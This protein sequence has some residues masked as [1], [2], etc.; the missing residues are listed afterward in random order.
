[1]FDLALSSHGDLIFSANRD[2]AGISGT[3]LL[4]QRMRIR[5][6]LQKGAWSYD[7]SG[8]L[9]SSLY[10][11]IG[12]A[13]EQAGNFIDPYVRE[14]LRPMSSEITVDEVWQGYQ[15]VKGKLF[16][17]PQPGTH[18]IVVIVV[19]RVTPAANEISTESGVQRRL[20]LALPFGT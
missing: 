18:G 1:M 12:M 8:T 10:Q 20:E 19:Y 2:L 7:S 14:A 5:L 17:E 16:S 11:L 15:D 6:I 9:G 4:E 3:D 13:P